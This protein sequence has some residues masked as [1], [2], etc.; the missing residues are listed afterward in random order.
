M[1]KTDAGIRDRVFFKVFFGAARVHVTDDEVEYFRDHP[2]EID[3]FSTPLNIH[4]VFLII[5]TVVGVVLVGMSKVVK[6][7][8]WLSFFSAALNEFLNLEACVLA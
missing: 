7:S 1:K 4:K 5:G 2:D 6:F 3:E 8:S